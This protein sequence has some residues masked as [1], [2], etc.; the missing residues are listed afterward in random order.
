MSNKRIA[1]LVILG[2]A[3]GA[4]ADTITFDGNGNSTGNFDVAVNW[5]PDGVPDAGDRIV[6]P[7]G[8]TCKVNVDSEADT[9][10][11]EDGGTLVI[12]SGETLTLDNDDHNFHTCTFPAHSC[13]F[14]DHSIVDGQ[15]DI[16]GDSGGGDA[17][18]KITN[19]THEFSGE[20]RIVG[21]KGQDFSQIE[22]ATDIKLVN[23]LAGIGDGILGGMTI[24]GLTGG[25]NRGILRNEGKVMAL[26]VL[27]FGDDDQIVIDADIEDTSDA[28]W[29]LDCGAIMEFKYGS[30]A[31]Q[32]QFS[33]DGF[34]IAGGTFKF[35]ANV[36]TCGDYRRRG[37][38][39]IDIVG[40]VVFQYAGFSG[41]CENPGTGPSTIIP[42]NC[43]S[44]DFFEI[45]SDVSEDCE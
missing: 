12:E 9:V 33:D 11:I 41:S 14:V 5:N 4:Q 35:N 39:G 8:K 2:L 15:L 40:S 18:L 21:N 23:K 43:A 36:R 3:V 7:D 16:V 10:E 20:G 26:N 13:I 28:V 24:T 30:T 34:N 32:G 25:T 31:L 6:I 27:V 44:D 42:N 17:V 1:A 22:I 19:A 45:A 37:C 29:S 38:G